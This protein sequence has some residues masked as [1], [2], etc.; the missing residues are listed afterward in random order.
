MIEI[1]EQPIQRDD[2]ARSK[3]FCFKTFW[4]LVGLHNN[5]YPTSGNGEKFV[6][7]WKTAANIWEIL[8][9]K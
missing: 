1:G 9:E 5:E 3:T 4:K 7:P 2:N 8:C 6:R